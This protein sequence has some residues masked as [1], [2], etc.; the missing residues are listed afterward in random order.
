M[1]ITKETIVD[2]ITIG[3]NGLVGYRE[4]T[5]WIEDGTASAA[6][7]FRN[8]LFPGQDL[9]GVPEKVVVVCNVVWT[10]EVIAAHQAALQQLETKP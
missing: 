2:E 10:P 5:R 8:T 7:F 4:T 9:T 1:A 3:L 6:T